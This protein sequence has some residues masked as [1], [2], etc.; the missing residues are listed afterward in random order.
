[1][2]NVVEIIFDQFLEIVERLSKHACFE[3]D[4]C[5]FKY[6]VREAVHHRLLDVLYVARDKCGRERDVI[7]TID[8]TGICFDYLTTC[9]WIQYLERI[10][11]EFIHDICP[12]KYAVVKDNSRKCREEPPRCDLLPCRHVTTVIHKKKPPKVKREPEIIIEKECVCVP[13]CKREPCIPKRTIVIREELEKR[14]KCGDFSVP[15]KEYKNKHE[16]GHYK[17]NIDHNNHQWNDCKSCKPRCT[18]LT[19]KGSYHH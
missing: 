18:G 14:H 5:A 8:I 15:V 9:K 3:F 4:E 13:E 19:D 17:G 10:A 16:F 12:P 1:M 2:A 11:K 6:R 7:A